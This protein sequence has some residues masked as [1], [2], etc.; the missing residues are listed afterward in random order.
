MLLLAHI[1]RGQA[2]PPGHYQRH[3]GGLDKAWWGNA[4]RQSHAKGGT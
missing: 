2:A 1:K 3:R 4:S